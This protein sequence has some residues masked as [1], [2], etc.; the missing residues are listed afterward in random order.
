[1]AEKDAAAPAVS[2]GACGYYTNV[3]LFGGPPARRGCGQTIPPGD[4]M[5]ASP[6]VTLPAGGTTTAVTATDTDGAFAQYGPAILLSGRPP[7]DPNK[8]LP[9][10]GA[11]KVS[12]K[13]KLTINS[14]AEVKNVGA[15][16]FN[17]SAVKSTAK[18]SKSAKSG[19]VKITKGDLVTA[20]DADGNPTT[21]KTIPASPPVGYT[22]EGK[23]AVGDRFKAV[24]NEQTVA[25]D[26]TIT[27]NAVHL[28][29]LG[30]NAVGDVVVAQAYARA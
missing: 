17:A 27:V 5:S 22:L 23:N 10:T 16:P 15:G 3:G 28:Y 9:P 29:L 30:P 21:T 2:G 1:M 8:P 11:L 25:A 26:G 4:K 6:S 19:T 13:G 20:T 7:A 12:T 14:T 18:A 24:F